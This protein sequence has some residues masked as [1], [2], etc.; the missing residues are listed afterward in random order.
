MFKLR[1]TDKWIDGVC[2]P[3]VWLNMQ[4]CVTTLTLNL[5]KR[6]HLQ[7][8]KTHDGSHREVPTTEHTWRPAETRRRRSRQNSLQQAA[9]PVWLCAMILLKSLTNQKL[10]IWLF[11]W[12]LQQRPPLGGQNRPGVVWSRAANVFCVFSKSFYKSVRLPC[13]SWKF[14]GF[15]LITND[16]LF[17]RDVRKWVLNSSLALLH[18]SR[19]RIYCSIMW[20]K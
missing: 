16:V 17:I 5:E 7:V 11:G 20:F 10:F 4:M 19:W 1:Q 13:R 12:Q 6:L 15:E 3:C 2:P 9:P 18:N 14:S 8:W